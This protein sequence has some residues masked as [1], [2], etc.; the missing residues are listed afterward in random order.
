MSRPR[1]TQSPSRHV[2]INQVNPELFEFGISGTLL[3]A[4]FGE[5]NGRRAAQSRA[6]GRP[7]GWGQRPSARAL[8]AG[9]SRSQDPPVLVSRS[10]RR[11]ASHL[12]PR[13]HGETPARTPTGTR[14][15]ISQTTPFP[16]EVLPPGTPT[17]PRLF[18][19]RLFRHL[20]LGVR[21]CSFLRGFW[22]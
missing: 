11:R 2:D 15:R 10:S 21:I 14:F 12:Q 7:R 9:P 1:S 8:A 5:T 13:L 20:S 3:R 22:L 18:T 4:W 17:L 6:G 19:V 16:A